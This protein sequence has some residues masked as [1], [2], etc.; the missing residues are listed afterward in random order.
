MAL[1]QGEHRI[2]VRTSGREPAERTIRIV[3]GR[4]H[5]LRFDARAGGGT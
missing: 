1:P 5:V 3:P 2:A 4:T